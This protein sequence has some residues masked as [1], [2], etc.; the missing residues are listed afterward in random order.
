MS[1]STHVIGFAPPDEQWRKMK[2]IW[3]S[4]RAAGI[5]VPREV[6]KFFG[7]E[8]PDE[9]G[10]EIELESRKWSEDSREGVEI[11]VEKLPKH[12]KLI[13]FYNSW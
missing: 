2:A 3:D 7:G 1:M 10:V 9:A 12:V 6:E 8:P 5:A 4:C 11:E 13:R